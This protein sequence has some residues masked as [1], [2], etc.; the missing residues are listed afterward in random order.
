MIFELEITTLGGLEIHQNGQPLNGLASR[1][2]E[3]LL[4]Y[5]AANPQ[6]HSR[7]MLADLLWD[8]RSAA[9][10]LG[11]LRVL[12]N[13]LRKNLGE[14]LEI[15][16]RSVR[17]PPGP[18]WRLDALDFENSIHLQEKRES[19]SVTLTAYSAAI[20]ETALLSYRGDFLAGVYFRE[21]S[22]FE[23]WAMLTRER[24]RL[25]AITALENLLDYYKRCGDYPN[26]IRT[27]QR[28]LEFDSL[29][30]GSH[31]ELMLL[32]AR[33]G[34]T[35]LALRQYEICRDLLGKELGVSPAPETDALHRKLSAAHSAVRSGLPVYGTPFIGRESELERITSLLSRPECRLI[36]LLGPGGIG[37][38]RLA[39]QAA[40]QTS[41]EFLH[42]TIFIPL[43][44]SGDI[45][46]LRMALCDS[47]ELPP[48][49]RETPRTQLLK[50]LSEQEILLVLD[51]FEQ[52][53][54]HAG[55]LGEILSAAPG[56]RMLVTSRIRLNLQNEWRLDVPGLEIPPSLAENPQESS[57][58]QLFWQV[59]RRVQ[60]D[61]SLDPASLPHVIRI[62]ELVMGAPL[63]IELAA[64][65][66]RLLTPD[67]I[68]EAIARDLNTLSTTSP[69]VPERHRSFRALVD[70]SWELLNPEER[71][72][73]CRLSVFEGGFDYS[74]AQSVA[75]M[76]LATLSGLVDKSFVQRE[77]S[78]RYAIHGLLRQYAAARLDECLPRGE[79][80]N[81]AHSRYYL[82]FVAC[83]E[84]DLRGPRQPEALGEIAS[85]LE[86]LR[87]ALNWA[88]NTGQIKL[89]APAL[90]ALM[91]Y[92]DLRG[93]YQEADHLLARLAEL[94][95]P[96][97]DAFTGWVATYRGW[98]SDRLARYTQGSSSSERG[99]T[100]FES[101]GHIHG[102]AIALGN[103]GLNAISRGALDEALSFLQRGQALALEA[104]DEACQ[105]RCLN[106]IGVVYKQRGD[107]ARARDLL[108]QSLGIFRALGDPQRIASLD[109]NLGAVLR[110]LGDFDAARA[111]YEENLAIRRR[112]DDPRG[113]A[114][115]L[116]NLG[117]LLAQVERFEGAHQAYVES[118]AISTQR[119]DL[120]GKSLCLHNLGDLE[121]NRGAYTLS[122]RHY[123]ESLAL[124]RRT[125]D[126]SGAAYSLV[127]L[128][129]ASAALGDFERARS[130]FRE[131][132]EGALAL[133]LMP[134]A[135]DAL[136]G[137]AVL[138]QEN[139]E[140]DKAV[141]LAVFVLSQPA[142]ERQTR[143]LLSKWEKETLSE[144]TNAE[145]ALRWAF[146]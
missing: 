6:A 143:M 121:R 103:L 87:A 33:N 108:L 14:P 50:A 118:L 44:G 104:G 131:A 64:A 144:V 88:T 78:G 86:N 47:L 53:V 133:K 62:C 22:R 123:Q 137:M 117:N 99:L 65:W 56:V 132:V 42:G 95:S 1:K 141:A 81:E 48:Q 9:Q 89:L 113:A 130:Y 17:L 107:F 116:V 84:A 54:A 60:P 77:G 76:G 96:D 72:V 45:E 114:L 39:T 83:R 41:T 2:A 3:A 75:L 110:A 80:P 115:A 129:H 142:A 111:C 19:Q 90:Q 43:T 139:G 73:F 112:L 69:D 34:Q 49:A 26:G 36:T 38:T 92:F 4:V 109:N 12:L 94:P 93:G 134:V 46:S 35:A 82:E 16:R 125:N 101:I 51:N 57:A 25:S 128:G 74:A 24:L 91:S 106:L 79:N 146:S 102:Q 135:L 66:L 85:E 71:T 20:F 29:H 13:S 61:F 126:Q 32:L 127:G 70:H 18:G 58:V 136:G 31:R 37:K 15:S 30:E 40:A 7:E 100:I 138:L 122:M 23:E 124:R 28:L 8:D 105:A 52:Y 10:A 68:A 98:I 63:G 59:A 55:L 97:D 119:D 67:Q 11:N 27:C 21:S 140:A 120:W 5:L 145:A